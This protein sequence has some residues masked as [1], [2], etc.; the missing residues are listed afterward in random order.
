VNVL[1]L[2]APP[3]PYTT[4]FRSRIAALHFV[5]AGCRVECA[6]VIALHQVESAEN[7]PT[8]DRVGNVFGH[9]TRNDDGFGEIAVL[10]MDVQDFLD[11]KS[12]RLNSSHVKSSYA[13]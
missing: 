3:L 6:L 2:F 5:S 1:R 8:A 9:L 12:T 7:R 10:L 4:L 11:R 13:V